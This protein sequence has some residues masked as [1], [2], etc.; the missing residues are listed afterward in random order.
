MRTCPNKVAK[1]LPCERSG[2]RLDHGLAPD[3]SK[4][5]R[6]TVNCAHRT[7]AWLPSVNSRDMVAFEGWA[8]RCGSWHVEHRPGCV[9]R[10]RDMDS[11]LVAARRTGSGRLVAQAARV[12]L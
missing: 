2:E 4:Y 1:P 3:R 6:L 10:Q 5:V 8:S 12:S 9:G 11:A 7:R